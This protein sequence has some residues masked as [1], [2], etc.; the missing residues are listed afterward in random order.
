MNVVFLGCTLNFGLEYN[1]SNTKVKLICDALSKA[2]ANCSIHAGLL[3]SNLLNEDVE[4]TV[5]NYSYVEYSRSG[6]VGIGELRN[7]N[8][9]IRY[10]ESHKSQDELNVGIVELPLLHTFIMYCRALR[11]CKYKIFVISHEWGPSL[12][13][14]GIRYF[15]NY[16]YSK[17]FGYFVDGILPI[18]EFIIEKIQSFNKPYLKLPALA[19]FRRFEKIEPYIDKQ[20]YLYCASA[21]YFRIVSWIIDSYLEYIRLGGTFQLK[22]I[23]SGNKQDIDKV[24]NYINV[25]NLSDKCVILSGLSYELLQSLYKGAI[26]LLIPLD[27]NTLQDTARFPQKIAEY[28]ASRRP[29]ITTP[30]GEIKYYFDN[31]SAILAEYTKKSYAEAMMMAEQ[32]SAYDNMIAENAYTIGKANFDISVIG[33]QLFNFFNSFNNEHN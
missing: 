9:L 5:E 3:G 11:K 12:Q 2:G 31:K 6:S 17:V 21:K 15:S 8:K 25:Y 18:S 33:K 16:V 13:V 19:D 27:P 22:M 24:K 32:D 20:Y 1:A 23:L 14:K 28:S 7:Y 4:K 10:L 26:G 30:I 29:I